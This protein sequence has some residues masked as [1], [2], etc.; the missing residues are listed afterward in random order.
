MSVSRKHRDEIT[1]LSP[2][3]FVKRIADAPFGMRMI[4]CDRI[5]RLVRSLHGEANQRKPSLAIPSESK[6][7]E[8]AR[9]TPTTRELQKMSEMRSEARRFPRHRACVNPEG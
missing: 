3:N 9:H 7:T 2:V 8:A 1:N 5:R 4:T 6:S